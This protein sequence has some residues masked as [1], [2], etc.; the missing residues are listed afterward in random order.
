MT[1][2]DICSNI[3]RKIHENDECIPPTKAMDEAHEAA[4]K[5]IRKLADE[6]DLEWGLSTRAMYESEIRAAIGLGVMATVGVIGIIYGI[7]K[8]AQK[9][10]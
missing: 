9:T 3:V 2:G 8:I 1:I 6:T 10:K 4:L 5:A 7:K